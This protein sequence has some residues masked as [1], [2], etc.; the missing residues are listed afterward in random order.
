MNEDFS[1]LADERL[2]ELAKNG[3][4]AI[5]EE[6]VRRF[7]KSLY[8]FCLHWCGND[9]D[10]RELVQDAFVAAYRGLARYKPSMPFAAWLFAIARRKCIDNS[11]RIKPVPDNDLPE[12][13]TLDT[14]STQLE[15]RDEADQ[16]WQI[17][18]S[19]LSAS[20]F[21]TLWLH[22]GE[23]MSVRD[24]A[25][26]MRRPQTYVRVQL[27]RARRILARCLKA[28]GFGPSVHGIRTTARPETQSVPGALTRPAPNQST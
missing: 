1:K 3:D 19:K 22:Y 24:I 2:A 20:Q 5:F 26:V 13:A 16:L 11:R 15:D 9:A 27:F 28:P 18:R 14:P 6:L 21:Q 12:S 4:L 8:S 25:Q 23:N 7:E 10:A 17:A